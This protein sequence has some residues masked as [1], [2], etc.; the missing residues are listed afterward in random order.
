VPVRR[1]IVRRPSLGDSAALFSGDS[2]FYIVSPHWPHVRVHLRGGPT[3]LF[4]AVAQRLRYV[5]GW[6]AGVEE[7][8]VRQ[9]AAA[10]AL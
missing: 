6:S 8:C 10:E 3:G 9:V 5:V 2:G 4:A 7:E 1:R